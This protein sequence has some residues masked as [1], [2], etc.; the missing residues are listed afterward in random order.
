[1]TSSLRIVAGLVLGLAAGIGIAAAVAPWLEGF[2][3]AVALFGDIWLNA[4]RMTVLPLLVALLITGVAS[5][6]DTATSG[7]LAGRALGWFALIAGLSAAFSA[8]V[9][10][11]ML[12]LWPIAPASRTALLA[13]LGGAPETPPAP[14]ALRDWFAGIVPSNPFRAAADGAI[15]PLVVFTLLFALAAARLPPARR[16]PLLAFFQAVVDAMLVLVGWVLAVAPFGVFALA[17]GVGRQGGVAAA[18]AIGQYLAMMVALA[19]LVTLAMYPLAVFVGRVSLRRFAVALAPPQTV[20]FS[21]QSSLA[22]LPAM[23]TAAQEK[24]AI[25][26]RVAGVVLPLAVAVFKATSPALNLGIVIFVAHVTGMALDPVR[27]AL[28][29]LVALVTSFGVAGIPG[30]VS[31]FTTTVPI[32]AVMGVPTELLVLLVAIEVIPDIF[33][34]VGNV[35]ADV[36]VTAILARDGEP[37][38]TPEPAAVAS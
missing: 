27:L 25:P 33:R 28:G 19:L 3:D 2:A 35:T 16:A 21:T 30:Q 6:H 5:T 8:F 7:R 29:V 13:G 15:L 36:A 11:A 31:F 38:P 32:S 10:P 18:G 37:E 12:A 9:T 24:L 1:M 23:L 34:T 17:L 26:P 22:S 14:V 20:A 4:L